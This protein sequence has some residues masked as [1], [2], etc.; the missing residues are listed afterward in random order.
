MDVIKGEFC[1][2]KEHQRLKLPDGPEMVRG[3][4]KTLYDF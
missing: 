1:R 4:A 3:S 2:E